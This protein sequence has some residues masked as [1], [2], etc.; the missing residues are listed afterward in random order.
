MHR[1]I[2]TA[3]VAL[4]LFAALST[5]TFAQSSTTNLQTLKRRELAAPVR[6]TIRVRHRLARLEWR[7]ETRPEGRWVRILQHTIHPK[8]V[9]ALGTTSSVRAVHLELDLIRNG[10][11]V[12]GKPLDRRSALCATQKALSAPAL[13]PV[14]YMV[15]LHWGIATIATVKATRPPVAAPAAK[16]E[17]ASSESVFPPVLG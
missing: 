6:H 14:S 9:E 5:V 2:G 8:N 10:G 13:R 11:L 4:V 17:D 12:L 7:R 16:R 3:A 15:Q 1:K